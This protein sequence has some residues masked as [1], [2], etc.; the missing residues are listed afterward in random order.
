MAAGSSAGIIEIPQN[1]PTER[2]RLPDGLQWRETEDV[3]AIVSFLG[4]YYAEDPDSSYRLRYSDSFF[5][6][7]FSSPD[8]QRCLSLSIVDENGMA[9][10]VLA[11]LHKVACN[12]LTRDVVSVNFL[13]L[14]RRYRNK[15]LACAMITEITR[16]VNL[17]GIYQAI[18]V[19]EK[20]Y[21]FSI[22]SVPYYHLPLDSVR[23][24]KLDYIS[25]LYYADIDAPMRGSTVEATQENVDAILRLYHK[26]SR[27]YRIH[28]VLS[29][30]ELEHFI[31]DGN[32]PTQI[33]YN[34]ETDEFVSYFIIDTYCID[35]AESFSVAYLYYW[36]GFPEIVKDAICHARSRG[37]VLFN[38]LDMG[39]N[40]EII[41]KYGF[42]EGTTS[43][44]YHLFN[45]NE[46]RVGNS[47]L[48]IVLF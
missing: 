42:L 48:S 7:L 36:S 43:L 14:S 41:Q 44:R 22:A 24:L 2:G 29:T 40:S 30:Q 28:E 18:F 9:G 19:G 26:D 25:T 23:L 11:K 17:L 6:F 46:K 31:R 45:W 1:I 13:C 33:L 4:E 39:S 16:L 3:P 35:K 37:I 27:K 32:G 20:D 21:G 12:S 5:R 15:R 38:I 10:Y 8:H 34:S 47:E